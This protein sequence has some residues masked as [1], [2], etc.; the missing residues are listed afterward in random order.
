MKR[1]EAIE[2]LG[3]IKALAVTA[4]DTADYATW[5]SQGQKLHEELFPLTEAEYQLVD[6]VCQTKVAEYESDNAS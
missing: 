4:R 3:T 2:R 1:V 6:E 5:I